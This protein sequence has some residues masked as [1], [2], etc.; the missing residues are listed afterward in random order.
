MTTPTNNDIPSSS[1]QDRLYNAE[2]FDEFMNSSNTNFT[3]RKGV[4]RWTLSGIRTV[5]SNWMTS[6]SSNA[7]GNTI[8]VDNALL[9]DLDYA[10]SIFRFMTDADIDSMKNTLGSEVPVD[11]AL[12]A[13]ID[14]G[15]K[16][17][18]FPHNVKGIYILSG[19]VTLPSAFTIFGTCSKPYSSITD[20][21]FLN[22][23]V[24]LRK[25]VGADYLFGAGSVFR[26]YGCNLDGRDNLR[27]LIN[28]TNQIRGGILE[29]CGIYRF[30][31]GVGSYG[32]TSIVVKRSSICSNNI[33]IRNLID[34]RIMDVTLNANKGNGVDNQVGANNNIFENVRNEWNEG[35]G[36]YFYGSVGNIITGELIDRSGSAN[37]V[38]L[39]GGS[40]LI[41]G[42]ISQRPARTLSEDSSYNTHFYVAG[43]KSKLCLSGVTT[44]TGIDD[45]GT[46]TL[47]PQRT[48]VIGGTNTDVTV[49][50]SGCDLSGSI[51]SPLRFDVTPATVGFRNNIGVDD[52]VNTG[53]YQFIKGRASIG[54]QKNAVI[55]ASGVGSTATLVFD[56][57]GFVDPTSNFPD[58]PKKRKII[59]ESMTSVSASRTV[60]FYEVSLLTR[61]FSSTAG[62]D[63]LQE[64]SYPAGAWAR[65]TATGVSINIALSADAKQITVTLTNVDGVGRFIDAALKWD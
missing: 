2:K 7:G 20:S 52:W 39:G 63:V 54:S 41:S 60:G 10:P 43:S 50:S 18:R 28:Q 62:F 55:L 23:G 32:Y 14:A 21:S 9:P 26:I 40:A 47:T 6:L 51:L 58:I 44:A 4:S 3:D 38:V 25:A 48:I 24:T 42:V 12:Q 57:T 46:G 59:I 17:V 19:L 1:V 31:Y 34:S 11:Y 22:K 27:P 29:D 64:T 5:I 33:G 13:V 45:G 35:I 15:Y 53:Q 36:Y 56:N 61:R 65:T 16:S 49:L 30:L 37:V 8:K